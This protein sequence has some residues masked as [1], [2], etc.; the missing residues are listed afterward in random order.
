MPKSILRVQFF[1]HEVFL[2]GFKI[3]TFFLFSAFIILCLVAVLFYKKYELNIK[4]FLYSQGI[5]FVK[6]DQVDHDKDFDAFMSFSHKDDEFVVKEII[7]SK[8]TNKINH[9]NHMLFL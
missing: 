9:F 1:Y 3:K 2:Y 8:N 6:E 5:T 4:V 7:S